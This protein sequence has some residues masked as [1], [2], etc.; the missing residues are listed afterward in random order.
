MQQ[1]A[2]VPQ[3]VVQQQAVVPQ[4]G[5]QQARSEGAMPGVVPPRA[6]VPGAAVFGRTEVGRA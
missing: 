1:Q 3:G 4:G 5:V 6:A 2:V